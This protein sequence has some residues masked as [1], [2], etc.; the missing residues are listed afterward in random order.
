MYVNDKR[1]TTIELVA[2]F[3]LLCSEFVETNA[4]FRSASTDLDHTLVVGDLTQSKLKIAISL[5]LGAM[6]NIF[7]TIGLYF[8]R[9]VNLTS[10]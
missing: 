1:E 4:T 5:I 6:N 3:N 10:R 9:R 2:F 7:H 8:R